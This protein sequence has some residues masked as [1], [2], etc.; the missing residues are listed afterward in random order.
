[1][2]IVKYYIGSL[3]LIIWKRLSVIFETSFGLFNYLPN[4]LGS[5]DFTILKIGKGIIEYQVTLFFKFYFSVLC[6]KTDL[7]TNKFGIF[8]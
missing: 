7:K 2:I 1:M 8:F 5:E 4:I 6:A 3:F